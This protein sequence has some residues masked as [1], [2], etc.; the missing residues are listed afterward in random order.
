M[1][2]LAEAAGAFGAHA[3]GVKTTLADLERRR[4]RFACIALLEDTGHFVCIYD[5]DPTTVYLADPPEQRGVVR[6]AFDRLWGGKALLISDVPI[7]PPAQAWSGAWLLAAVGM[8]AL[9]GAVLGR[10]VL[11]GRTARAAAAIVIAVA[12]ASCRPAASPA[13]QPAA[14]RVEPRLIDLGRIEVGDKGGKKG[15]FTVLNGGR[16]TL[17]I[18]GCETSC[19][20]TL[21][22]ECKQSIQPGRRAT[23][24]VS[25]KPRNSVGEQASTI[26]LQTDD[27]SKPLVRVLV[28]W[29][30]SYAITADPSTLDL[31]W[32]RS[33]SPA[34][35]VVDVVSSSRL[36]ARRLTARS[37]GTVS[38]TWLADA[39]ISRGPAG[40]TFA[41]RK[42]RI[43]L[44]ATRRDG[45]D[46]AEVRI[47]SGDEVFSTTV[48]VTWRSAPEVEVSPM[49]FFQSGVSPGEVLEKK[50]L[51][52]FAGGRAPNIAAVKVDGNDAP[53]R[54]EPV[55]DSDAPS[56]RTVAFSL[57]A[58]GSPGV[59]KHELRVTAGAT[60]P[61]VVSVPVTLI[62]GTDALERNSPSPTIAAPR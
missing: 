41:R 32:V 24:S 42:L 29:R 53:F 51:V 2:Q 26:A 40:E 21:L 3:V 43:S 56:H 20:C 5:L 33:G 49:A 61:H 6:D 59:E 12:T 10:T 15:E 52:R 8:C 60:P 39:S 1:Q 9:I 7:E 4:Q 58:G 54:I 37:S 34:E 16:A 28:H 35:S 23:I 14:V 45:T 47:F 11:R 18:L 17:R 13:P 22:G 31:G 46:F 55:S 50:L 57:R 62:V 25:V 27:P 36:D 44:P 19:G 48:P 30:E 38:A